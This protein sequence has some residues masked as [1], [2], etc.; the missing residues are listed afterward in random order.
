VGFVFLDDL[1]VLVGG[2]LGGAQGVPGGNVPRGTFGVLGQGL[3]LALLGQLVLLS[4][5]AGDFAEFGPADRAVLGVL[6][7]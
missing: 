6:G 5:V 3:G 1:K 2:D 4:L 7:R